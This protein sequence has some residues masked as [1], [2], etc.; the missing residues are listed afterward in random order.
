MPRPSLKNIAND[1]QSSTAI[2][3][4]RAYWE[5]YG[6]NMTTPRRKYKPEYSGAA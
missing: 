6:V 5:E 4:Y 3:I 1:A 2:S